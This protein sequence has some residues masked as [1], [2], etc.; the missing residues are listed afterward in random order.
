MLE[1]HQDRLIRGLQELYHRLLK[2][3]AW[4]VL[5]LAETDGKPLTHDILGALGLLHEEN[6]GSGDP[7]PFEGD[8][9]RLMLSLGT[10]VKGRVHRQK[11]VSSELDCGLHVLA[12]STFHYGSME[13]KPTSPMERIGNA[14]TI[15]ASP[16][17]SKIT[18]SRV[19][20]YQRDQSPNTQSLHHLFQC[21]ND[22]RGGALEPA[23]K[24]DDL[25]DSLQATDSSL[26]MLTPD[27]NDDMGCIMDLQWDQIQS[28]DDINFDIYA[29]Y[30]ACR[31][32]DTFT[33]G[34]HN[35]ADIYSD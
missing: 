16:N 14:S 1:G 19:P 31:G 5:P 22:Q 10:E 18:S 9:Q 28:F 24:V 25:D 30:S 8:R 4:N 3:G 13:S 20:D 29:P 12:E 23:Q 11:P 32:A 2:V 7:A 34:L 27:W 17:R 15:P 33:G 26:A 35:I 6:D 21:A